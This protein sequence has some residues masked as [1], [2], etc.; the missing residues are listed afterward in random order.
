MQFL[1]MILLLTACVGLTAVARHK[2]WPAPLLVTGVAL[3]VAG[4][5]GIPEFEIDSHV[6]LTLVLPPLLY[7]AALDVSLL[8]FAR[9]RKHITRLGI[10]LVVVTAAVVGL[11]AWLLV[12]DMTL[13]AALLLGAIVAPPDAVSAAAIGRKLGLP[14]PVMTV[15]SGE[16]LINDAASLTL[17]KVFLLVI[18]GAWRSSCWWWWSSSGPRSSTPP[19]T[20]PG[21]GVTRRNGAGSGC[22]SG[23]PRQKRR[24]RS[25][26]GGA[27]VERCWSRNRP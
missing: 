23:A 22:C 24:A 19:T 20:S 17:F 3:I 4:I 16:S 15:L 6:I 5:P 8:N 1:P 14:R 25:T 10:F 26:F 12:P 7:S 2:G 9:S 11:V 27:G 13:P 18:G 21:S